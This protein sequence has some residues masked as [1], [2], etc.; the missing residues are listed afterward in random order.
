MNTIKLNDQNIPYKTIRKNNKNTYF[1]FKN[2]YI[3]IHLSTRMSEETALKH[4]VDNKEIFFKKWMKSQLKVNSIHTYTFLGEAFQVIESDDF[5]FDMNQKK[6][7]TNHSDSHKESLKKIEKKHMI[8]ILNKLMLT[9]NSNPYVDLS[10]VK[11]S[12]RYTK[13]RH[14]SCNKIKRTININLYLIRYPEKYIEYVFLHE[15]SHLVHAN[16]SSKFYDLFQKLCP[17][18]LQLR[19][20]LKEIYR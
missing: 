20:E 11:L 12:T 19:K 13:T 10:N 4:I 3:Q 5:S 6:I 18:Y 16:H 1:Y 17:N 8:T 2:G 15:I 14:G 9:Y 7:H